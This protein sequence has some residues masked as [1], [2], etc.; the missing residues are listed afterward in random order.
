MNNHNH[1]VV[2][3]FDRLGTGEKAEAS[4]R[5]MSVQASTFAYL[6]RLCLCESSESRFLSMKMVDNCEVLQVKNYAGVIFTPDGT[7]IEILPKIGRIVSDATDSEAS[8]DAARSALLTMLK[9]LTNLHHLRT[10]NANIVTRRMPL[11]E[12]FISQFLQTVNRLVKRGLRNDY[13]TRNENLAVL[14]GK[15]QLGEHVK[16]NYVNRHRFYVEY[17]EYLPDRP[18]NRLI[19]SALVKVKT[20]C[21]SH[22]NQKLLRELLFVFADVPLSRMVSQ[23]FAAVRID[24]GMQHYHSPLQWA[25][26][27]LNDLSPLSGKGESEATSLLFP[28]ERVFEHF[29]ADTL[30]KTALPDIKVQSQV[31]SEYLVSCK[32]TKRFQLKPDLKIERKQNRAILDTKWK[33]VNSTDSDNHFGLSQSDFYQMFAYGHKYLN[34]FGDLFLIYPAHDRFT[35]ALSFSFDFDKDLRLWVVPF[36]CQANIADKMRMKWPKPASWITDNVENDAA[37]R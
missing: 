37:L 21:R 12:V 15:L 17:D 36:D 35:E 29:V 5:I 14:K 30:R 4:N 19:H 28:M 11:L 1:V 24:R 25:K 13:V 34:G 6:K 10:E 31:A 20:F 27:I 26:L 8:N 23:D 3:E 2:Y 7:H 32:G 22:E 16:R 9:S 33:L 18:A